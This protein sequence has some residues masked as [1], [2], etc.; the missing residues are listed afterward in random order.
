MESLYNY[1]NQLL[2]STQ[3]LFRRD[4]LDKI[5]WND[6]LIGVIGARG[7]GKTTCLLQHLTETNPEGQSGLYVS[8]DNLAN[9]YPTIFALAETFVQ[10]G[11]RLLIIDEIHKSMVGQKRSR[12]FMI[13]FQT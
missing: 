11:G 8:M 2:A 1:Q 5:D 13:C 9:P 12:I 4:L 3:F 6:R 7:V 10:R